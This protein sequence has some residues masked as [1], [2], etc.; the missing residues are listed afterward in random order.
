MFYFLINDV[1]NTDYN[2]VVTKRPNMPGI[3]KNYN[4]YDIPG[5]DG[6]LYEWLGTVNDIT[7]NIECNY[8]SNPEL[9]HIRW[10]EIKKW[11]LNINNKR[12]TLSDDLDYYY[13]IKKIE[14][15]ENERKIIKSGEF[16]ISF[17]C[18]AYSYLNFGL[19]SVNYTKGI[20]NLYEQSK[21]IYKIVGEGLCTLN[22]NGNE[23]KCNVGQNLTIDTYLQICYRDDGTLQNTAINADYADLELIEGDNTIT[24]TEGFDLTVIPNWRCI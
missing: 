14:I 16:T 18:E 24:I 3:V 22:V 19:N 1:P 5:R 21:P 10:K 7:I 9:W 17:I 8:I 23:C 2:F 13:R 12:L 11:I 6:M 15:S 20:H 4:E